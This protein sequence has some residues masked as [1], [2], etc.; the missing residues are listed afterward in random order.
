MGAAPPPKLSFRERL[1]TLRHLPRLALEMW[2]TSRWLTLGTIAIRVARAVQ[3]VLILYVGKLIVDEVVRL[4]ELPPLDGFSAWLDDG[5]LGTLSELLVLEFALA[6]LAHVLGRVGTLV[7]SLLSELYTNVMSVKLMEHATS[8]DLED[9]ESSEQQDKLDRARRQAMGRGN[10]VMQGFALGQQFLTAASFTLGVFIYGPLLILLLAVALVP[11]FIGEAHFNAEAYRLAWV[12]TAERR[13]IDYV[14]LLGASV[15]TAKEVKLFGLGPYFVE[16]FRSLSAGLFRANRRLAYRRAGWGTLFA[17]LSSGA[18]YVAY[19]IVAWRTVSGTLTIGDL[20]FLVT[21]LT[22]LRGLFEDLLLGFSQLAGQALYLEDL[23]NF[24]DI[25]PRIVSKPGAL[26]FPQPMREGFRFEEVGF[27][28]PG[29]ERWAVRGL[30]FDLTPGEVL[31]L[32]GEN[33]SGKTTVVKLLSRLYDPDEGRILLDG[34]D[35][36][37]YDVADLHDH[38]G[39]IFQDFVRYNLTARENVGLGRVEA[40]GDQRRIE[41]AA[42]RGLAD[43]V[44]SRLP[45]QWEQQLGKRFDEGVD[46]S[47]GEWQKIAIARAYM[48]DAELLILDEPTAALDA[49]A[50]F[51]VFQRFRDLSR[52]RTAILI[53]HRFSTVR[54][55]DRILVLDR[56]RMIEMGSHA[57]LLALGGRYAE[58]FEL[59]A[60][61]YR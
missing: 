27:R 54:M 6:I 12:R 39:V 11:A 56:G 9:F 4:T 40:A 25:E 59:Q 21:S 51:E 38:I 18:Y 7:D 24:L 58:L 52:G 57:E 30:T 41:A 10:V 28:Y 29:S 44:V 46:L 42:E 13:M 19:A 55:A 48:R 20:S 61:G 34:V 32:V 47:G 1:G 16:R 23:Y 37:D 50:E 45:A 53:S 5:R 31:A 26:P 33:G 22:R 2:H 3:P 14:R 36:R 8:L 60:A 49:R 17:V 35:L 43:E 15:E